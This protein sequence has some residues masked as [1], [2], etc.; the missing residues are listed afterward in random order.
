MEPISSSSSGNNN[1][2]D[3][4]KKEQAEKAVAANESTPKRGQA[5]RDRSSKYAA[6]E[7]T[8]VESSIARRRFVSA[9]CAFGGT[10]I[11]SRMNN[12]PSST[13]DTSTSSSSNNIK[14]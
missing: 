8:E 2:K 6:A 12:T 13:P 3:K 11:G 14:K 5:S 9:V 7:P 10:F 1:N 4:I